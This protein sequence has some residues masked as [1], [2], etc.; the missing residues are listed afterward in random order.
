M[1]RDPFAGKAIILGADDRGA[2]RAPF[3]PIQVLKADITWLGVIVPD[4][5]WIEEAGRLR[6]VVTYSRQQRKA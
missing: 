6:A 3:V 2:T 1:Q 4:V 5:Q